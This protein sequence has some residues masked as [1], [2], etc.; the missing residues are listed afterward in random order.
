M[1]TEKQD[2]TAVK[3]AMEYVRLFHPEVCM[4]VFN[5]EGRW[6]YMDEDFNAP[7][8]DKEMKDI[9]ILEQASDSLI[10]LPFVYEI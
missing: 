9:S 1:I 3:K 2:L 7:K 10:K 4:V 6:F 8:F 5:K